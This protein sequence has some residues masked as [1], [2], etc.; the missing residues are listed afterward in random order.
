MLR[1]C[2]P[3][4]LKGDYFMAGDTNDDLNTGI[5]DGYDDPTGTPTPL[6]RPASGDAVGMRQIKQADYD[7]LAST[8]IEGDVVYVIPDPA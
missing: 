2:S 8:D 5:Y 6:G 7:A 1:L 3:L 4:G